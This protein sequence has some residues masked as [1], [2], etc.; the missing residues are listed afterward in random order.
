MGLCAAGMYEDSLPVISELN[1]Y[2]ENTINEI[3]IFENYELITNKID[4]DAI[5]TVAFCENKKVE[6]LTQA[7]EAERLAK[8]KEIEEEKAKRIDA[9]EMLSS[10]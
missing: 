5:K 4:D 10:Y 2:V 7:K 1:A 3:S 9:F 8:V 6:E